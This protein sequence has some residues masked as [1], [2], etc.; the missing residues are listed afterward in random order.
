MASKEVENF[1][2]NIDK[3]EKYVWLCN[4]CKKFMYT[5]EYSKEHKRCWADLVENMYDDIKK[6]NEDNLESVQGMSAEFLEEVEFMKKKYQYIEDNN[7]FEMNLKLVNKIYDNIVDLV[8]KKREEA[9][10]KMTSLRDN[11]MKNIQQN[12]DKIQNMINKSEEVSGKLKNELDKMKKTNPVNFCKELLVNNVS[13]DLV[14]DCS[15]IAT[16]Q[17]QEFTRIKQSFI[18]TNT[19]VYNDSN[20]VIDQAKNLRE[21]LTEKIS[22]FYTNYSK[23]QSKYAFTVVMNMKEFI[24]YLIDSNKVTKVSYVNDFVI[25]CYARW[26]DISGD[27]LILTGGE[28]DYIESLDSCYMFKFRKFDGSDEGF[29]AKVFHKASMNYRRRAHSLIYFN[30]YM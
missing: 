24:V 15:D 25:P 4:D 14:D 16:F 30:D 22:N 10:E 13:S 28:K 6:I 20:A 21:F 17:R 18:D 3:N 7:P 27:K 12:I 9:L 26:I 23:Y 29:S 2:K 11:Y 8:N 19:V 1:I 5:K